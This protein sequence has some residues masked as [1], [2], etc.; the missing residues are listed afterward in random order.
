MDWFVIFQI[1]HSS[2]KAWIEF[3]FTAHK[4]IPALLLSH[5]H[6]SCFLLPPALQSE[7]AVWA[8]TTSSTQQFYLWKEEVQTRLF[9]HTSGDLPFLVS[10]WVLWTVSH[11]VTPP[12]H[13]QCQNS[14]KIFPSHTRWREQ[15][16][17]ESWL[18][19]AEDC[20]CE[21]TKTPSWFQSF[22]QTRA[23]WLVVKFSWIFQTLDVLHVQAIHIILSWVSVLFFKNLPFYLIN[24]LSWYSSIFLEGF[25]SMNISVITPVVHIQGLI[26]VHCATLSMHSQVTPGR[27]TTTF[28][29]IH[30]LITVH[31]LVSA[32]CTAIF[33][34]FDSCELVEHLSHLAQD[35]EWRTV[36]V[37]LYLPYIC[38]FNPECHMPF[39]L[40]FIQSNTTTQSNRVFH[41]IDE[42]TTYKYALHH[43][44]H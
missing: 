2:L 29:I 14:P 32:V 6:F 12:L 15:L 30:C 16:L 5:S 39:I 43:H 11:T 8:D 28:L 20:G 42:I 36:V 21:V 41:F 13:A 34:H 27:I 44:D 24:F 18:W 38:T 3:E 35:E 26:L 31:I 19:M 7:A 10:L 9:L 37:V 1:T 4:A 33:Q 23:K 22:R 40:T 17:C 25:K